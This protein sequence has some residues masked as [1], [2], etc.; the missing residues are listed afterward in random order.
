MTVWEGVGVVGEILR[1]HAG[2]AG[3]VWVVLTR[4]QGSCD[5]HLGELASIKSVSGSGV[6]LSGPW[7][8]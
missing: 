7:V 3:L 5:G 4:E 1:S 8:L 6:E 2:R